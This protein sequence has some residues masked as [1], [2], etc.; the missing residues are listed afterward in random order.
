[1]SIT[2][3][4][5]LPPQIPHMKTLLDSLYINGFAVDQSETGTGKTYV[6]AAIIREMDR[7]AFIVCPKSVIPQ[8]EKILKKFGLKATIINYEKLGRG[9]TKWLKWKKLQCLMRPWNEAAKVDRPLF[10]MD[11]NS[12]VI[13]DEGHRC[14]GR[15]T[16]NSEMMI[17]LTDQGYKVLASSA[18]IATT[19]LEM[20]AFGFMAKLHELHNFKHF[21][22]AHGAK[23]LGKWGAMTFDMASKEAANA[24][25]KLNE[26]LFRTRKCS[27]RLTTEDFGELFP[28]THI[29]A[30]A[31][32]LGVM[33]TKVQAAYDEMEYELSRLEEKSAKYKDH[34]FAIMMKARRKAELCKVPLFVEMIEELYD[35]GKSVACFVNFQE[36]VDAI[37][38]RLDK[39]KKLKGTIGYIVGGQSTKAR[40]QDIADFNDDKKRI[41][42]INI[43]AGG[44]GISL[45]DLNGKFPRASIISP[46]YS[47]YELVQAVGRIWRQGGLTKSYQR[48]VF[49]AKTIEEEACWRV[50]FRI[51][52][53]S[54][55]NDADMA[56][57]IQIFG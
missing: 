39:I 41:L 18:T 5:L 17:S 29:V 23:F 1:M 10:F 6:A 15:D 13:L 26:Y 12:L 35:E 2:T 50:Q 14:K 48:I 55:L 16:S 11:Q 54:A 49:A 20:N 33:T 22:R 8:W 4:G 51:N 46:N 57:G 21:C 28:E 19:P 42:I 31:Y 40:Q 56:A 44:T 9:N 27:S 34:I 53:L 32:D 38:K 36:T 47:A 24:M 52:N 37:T 45:H 3:E 43:K 25:L 30:E 7:P